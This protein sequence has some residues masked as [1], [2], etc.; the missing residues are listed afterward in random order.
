[1][2]GE[3]RHEHRSRPK[4]DVASVEQATHRGVNEWIAGH[5]VSPGGQTLWIIAARVLVIA[6]I[7][8]L[9]LHAAFHF[10]FLYEVAMPM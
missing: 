4:V 10:K 7:Q 3:K 6:A 9:A 8:I 1:M 5:T 2:M